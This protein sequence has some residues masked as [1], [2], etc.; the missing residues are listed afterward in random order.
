MTSSSSGTRTSSPSRGRR[1]TNVVP[2]PGAVLTEEQVKAHT[3]EHGPAYA[4]PRHVR[5][6]AEI[7][8][9]GTN[10]PD[11]KALTEEAARIV[12]SGG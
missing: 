8:L 9:A 4:H 10:K 6:I 3:L 2:R 12:A 7:P 11:R 1:I 5:F